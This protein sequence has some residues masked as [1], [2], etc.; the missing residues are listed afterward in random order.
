MVQLNHIGIAVADLPRMKLLF[1]ILG[2]SLDHSEKVPE[3]GVVTHFL[4]I[5]SS[6]TSIELLEP[7][8]PAGTIAKFMEKKGPGIHHLSFLLKK[9]ELDVIS[10]R[11]KE[12]KF[13]LVYEEAQPGAHQMK[14]NFIH[15]SSAGGLL[16]EI[17]EPR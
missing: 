11:L 2:I 5:P 17:M 10:H 16:I 4:P 14:V 13:R 15:P 9:G 6:A 8:D 7:S 3:Q 1:E 12:K